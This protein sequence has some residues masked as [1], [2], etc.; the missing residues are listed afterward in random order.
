[1]SN[2][3][4]QIHQVRRRYTIGAELVGP[5]QTHFRVWAPKAQHVDLV[6][7]GNTAKDAT[8]TIHVMDAEEGGYFSGT[9][10]AGASAHYRF[11]VNDGLYPD[12][13]SRFQPEGPHGASC[14]IDP[15]QF[16]WTDSQW[17]GIALKG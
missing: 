5:D 6:L 9:A 8:Q 1:M 15:A 7:E 2:S 17:P 10:A 12:P 16:R 4:R 13:A 11:R 3:K 14:I